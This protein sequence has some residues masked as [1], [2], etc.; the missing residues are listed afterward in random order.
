MSLVIGSFYDNPFTEHLHKHPYQECTRCVMNTSDPWITFNQKG[1]CNHCQRYDSYLLSSGSQQDKKQRLDKLV[2]SIKRR[3]NGKPY[4]CIMGLSGGVDS[5]YLA[6]FVV[7]KLGL[8]PLIVHVDAGWNS[9]LAIN[10]I[11]NI[12]ESLSL[13][14]HT[15]VIDWPEMRDIQRSFFLSGVANLDVPQ[16]HAFIATLY[17]VAIKYGITDI[18]NG[19]NM[20]TESILPDAWGYD[21]SDCIHIKAIHNKYGRKHLSNYPFISDFQR[22]F[23]YPFVKRIRTHRILNLIDYNKSA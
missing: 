16:D 6:W 14:L 19:G 21:A 17:S 3:G 22:M 10:N 5:S 4:D 13:D 8:R 18:L 11:Q 15:T 9:E 1:I 23:Y 20:Q 2:E 7:T 12:V